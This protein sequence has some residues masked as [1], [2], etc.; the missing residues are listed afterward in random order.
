[1]LDA[2]LGKGKPPPSAP[3]KKAGHKNSKNNF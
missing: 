2:P 3:P 1:M